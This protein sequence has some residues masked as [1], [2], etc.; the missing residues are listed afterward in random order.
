MVLQVALQ[1]I[2]LLMFAVEASLAVEEEVHRPQVDDRQVD[3]RQVGL[4]LWTVATSWVITDLPPQALKVR[5]PR[6]SGGLPK[7][8]SYMQ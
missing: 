4:L 2:Q 1:V 3:C 7:L 5:E 6:R 8:T